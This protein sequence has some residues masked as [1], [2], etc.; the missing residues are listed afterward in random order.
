MNKADLLHPP[1]LEGTVTANPVRLS[2]HPLQRVGAFALA[3]LAGVPHP[4]AITDAQLDDVVARITDHAIEAARVKAASGNPDPGA[5]WWKMLFACYPNAPETHAQRHKPRGS[6]EASG[7]EQ[8]VREGRTLPG[9]PLDPSLPC[10]FCAAPAVRRVGKVEFPLLASVEHRN[11]TARGVAGFPLCR[12]CLAS[13]WAIP[14]A[15]RHY[16]LL[17]LFD[18]SDEEIAAEFAAEA[19]DANLQM[20]EVKATA[21]PAREKRGPEEVAV[22]V[23]RGHG[24]QARAGPRPE[25]FVSLVLFRNGNQEPELSLRYMDGRRCNFVCALDDQQTVSWGWQTATRLLTAVDRNGAITRHGLT[26]LARALFDQSDAT[27]LQQLTAAARRSVG[28]GGAARLDD[29]AIHYVRKVSA[30]QDHEIAQITTVAQRVAG[31]LAS[32]GAKGPFHEFARAQA[33]PAELR[34][35]FK[36][37]A[38]RWLLHEGQGEPLLSPEEF[39]TLFPEDGGWWQRDLL[40]IAVVADL[41][42]RGWRPDSADLDALEIPDD[43]LIDQQEAY[44]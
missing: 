27:F 13:G 14:Y 39:L 3:H 21:P 1:V 12:G 33:R 37:Q 43:N 30:V 22:T 11:V 26:A 5:Y 7:L 9:E 16:G 44:A 38:V 2:P 29:L 23:L 31:L 15:S 10:V 6:P 42:A 34:R 17:A 18:S 4:S 32:E 20:I 41:H 24:S 19:V 8:R 25:D 35:W 28:S 40:F 36:K